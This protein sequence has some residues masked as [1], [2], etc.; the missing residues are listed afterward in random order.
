MAYS[1]SC[2][3]RTSGMYVRNMLRIYVCT[4]ISIYG[5]LCTYVYMHIYVCV[6]FTDVRAF[7]PTK[8][9]E[10]DTALASAVICEH[11]EIVKE[12]VRIS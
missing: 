2:R 3:P 1:K 5:V 6:S 11:S 9:E 12:L 10:G 7:Y 4:Y 8:D